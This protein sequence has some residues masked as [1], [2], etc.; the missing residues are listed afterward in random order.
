[1]R[2]PPSYWNALMRLECGKSSCAALRLRAV[3]LASSAPRAGI[4]RNYAIAWGPLHYT[5][6]ASADGEHFAAIARDAP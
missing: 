4:G 5:L 6:E 2:W 3:V 1:M